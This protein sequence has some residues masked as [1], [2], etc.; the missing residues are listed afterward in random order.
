M[1]VWKASRCGCADVVAQL[2]EPDS[3][4][5]VDDVDDFGATPLMVS[6]CAEHGATV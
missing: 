1:D 4:V 6:H 3:G 2:L 5:A